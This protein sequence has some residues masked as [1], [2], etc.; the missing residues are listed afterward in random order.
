MTGIHYHPK[1]THE[2]LG[3]KPRPVCVLGKYYQLNYNSSP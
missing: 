2:V 3:N 1:F